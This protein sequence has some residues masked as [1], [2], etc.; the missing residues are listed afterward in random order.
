MKNIFRKTVQKVRETAAKVSRTVKEHPE[1]IL[2]GGAL[3]AVSASLVGVILE[4]RK[5]PS[6]DV[7]RLNDDAVA[8]NTGLALTTFKHVQEAFKTALKNGDI[9]DENR[10]KI[11]PDIV[12]RDDADLLSDLRLYNDAS[13]MLNISYTPDRKDWD[14][15]YM[16]R[17][18][19]EKEVLNPKTDKEVFGPIGYDADSLVKTFQHVYDAFK[20]G[21]EA[22]EDS[23][24]VAV[25][26]G[27]HG[28]TPFDADML[29]LLG[30]RK[31]GERLVKLFYWSEDENVVFGTRS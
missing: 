12:T 9:D 21:Y 13:G 3:V 19:S 26:L 10:L 28:M 1:L 4:Y 2:S 29:D 14:T 31:K 5:T 8:L 16:G 17:R 22:S 15:Y 6:A 30:L 24:C 20:A 18:E 23:P 7:D 27:E 11:S 25:N